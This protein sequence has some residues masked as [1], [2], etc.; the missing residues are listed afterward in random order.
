MSNRRRK[1]K[2]LRHCFNASAKKK[3]HKIKD[4]SKEEIMAVVNLIK[5]DDDDVFFIIDGAKGLRKLLSLAVKALSDPDADVSTN[6]LLKAYFSQFN[7]GKSKKFDVWKAEHPDYDKSKWN[8]SLDTVG[9][10][11][12]NISTNKD[13][14]SDQDKHDPENYEDPVFNNTIDTN[15]RV[16]ADTPTDSKGDADDDEEELIVHDS[17]A[18]YDESNFPLMSKEFKELKDNVDV[19]VRNFENYQDENNEKD[20]QV[21]RETIIGDILKMA[22]TLNVSLDQNFYDLLLTFYPGCDLVN[23]QA[24]VTSLQTSTMQS[25]IK[26]GYQRFGYKTDHILALTV[27]QFEVSSKTQRYK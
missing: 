1:S 2:I 21:A 23:I 19:I 27:C 26:K 8:W 3:G 15:F 25:L 7:Y 17:E 18:D 14:D 13:S 10:E 4:A 6:T 20:I 5:S 9:D 24:L 16:I 22:V 11:A 12:A